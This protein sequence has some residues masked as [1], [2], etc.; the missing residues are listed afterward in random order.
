MKGL[1]VRGDL[2]TRLMAKT[3]VAETGCWLWGA[4]HNDQGY[5]VLRVNDKNVYAHRA[6][7]VVHFGELPDGHCVLHRCDVP[8]CINPAHLFVGSKADNTKDMVAKGRARGWPKGKRFPAEVV[9][10]RTST[11][12]RQRSS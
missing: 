11:R 10:R 3:V 1:Y 8:A 4:A 6:S 9:R 7:W 12:L 2:R 5:G